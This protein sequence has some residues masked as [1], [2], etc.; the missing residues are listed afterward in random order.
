MFDLFTS[1]AGQKETTWGKILGYLAGIFVASGFFALN[2]ALDMF[3]SPID[4]GLTLLFFFIT[5]FEVRKRLAK[6][7]QQIETEDEN[8]DKKE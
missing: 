5:T 7:N 6:K 2:Q 1:P 4:L 3:S 8:E